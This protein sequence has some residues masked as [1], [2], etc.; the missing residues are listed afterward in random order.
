MQVFLQHKP[1]YTFINTRII[2]SATYYVSTKQS[3]VQPN[4]GVF[5]IASSW[6]RRRFRCLLSPEKESRQG[7]KRLRL[8]N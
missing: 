7:E 6:L 8:V 2:Q 5:N 1:P 3:Y 4:Q